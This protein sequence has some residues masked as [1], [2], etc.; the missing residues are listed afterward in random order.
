[1]TKQARERRPRQSR[2]QSG[3]N[4]FDLY[5]PSRP[6]SHAQILEAWTTTSYK[7]VQN[8]RRNGKLTRALE[9]RPYLPNIGNDAERINRGIATFMQR[10]APRAP[11]IPRQMQ[12]LDDPPKFLYRGLNGPLA[13]RFLKD[14]HIQDN[15]YL[16]FSREPGPARFFAVKKWSPFDR[17]SGVI[18]VLPIKTVPTGTP[19][20]WFI[21]DAIAD[22]Q[23]FNSYKTTRRYTNMS[24]SIMDEKEVLLPPGRVV[25][26]KRATAAER[27]ACG[28]IRVPVHVYM[29]AYY[30]NMSSKSLAGKKIMLKAGLPAR[31]SMGQLKND[32]SLQMYRNLFT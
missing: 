28:L 13:K 3:K 1:M 11:V 24:L 15:G 9:N 20:I 17:N 31:N 14:K 5:A 7:G 21:A 10:R 2:D 23:A 32:V 6:G 19:W 25:A 12:M 30:P 22:G 4:A 8:L 18:L 27:K 16:A 26:V 29:I